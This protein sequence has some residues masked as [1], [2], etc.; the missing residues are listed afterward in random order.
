M[1]LVGSVL[2]CVQPLDLVYGDKDLLLTVYRDIM[3]YLDDATCRLVISPVIA[4]LVT[5]HRKPGA[6][7]NV[8]IFS[9]FVTDWN[10]ARVL[11]L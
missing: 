11:P 4:D 5:N 1:F 10:K 9:Y 7:K 6:R 8:S 3:T 2:F